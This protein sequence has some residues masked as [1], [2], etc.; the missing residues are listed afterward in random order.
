LFFLIGANEAW[1]FDLTLF[2]DSASDAPDIM[3][4]IQCAGCTLVRWG[5]LGAT[6]SISEPGVTDKLNMQ[7]IT[8]S[9]ATAT[10][11]TPSAS[12]PPPWLLRISGI[13][14]NGAAMDT[15]RLRWAQ[16]SSNATP[17]F[18]LIGSHLTA[19]KVP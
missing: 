17:T 11:G 19:H 4:A 15:V 18:L 1:A 13:V 14:V 8:G 5:G 7:V 2:V 9:N 10:F 16:N 12:F 6:T 3:V